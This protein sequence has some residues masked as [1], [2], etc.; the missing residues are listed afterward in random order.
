ML[1]LY[2]R[3]FAFSFSPYSIAMKQL[4]DNLL[5]SAK[6]YADPKTLLFVG[7]AVLFGLGSLFMKNTHPY[8][9]PKYEPFESKQKRR[10]IGTVL[11]VL[12]SLVLGIAVL[13]HIL[14]SKG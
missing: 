9:G 6:G 2:E 8:S 5:E 14:V 3:T 4:I 10:R 12:A 13:V 7:S 11:Y 1:G